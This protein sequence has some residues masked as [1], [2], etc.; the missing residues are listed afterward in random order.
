[1]GDSSPGKAFSGQGPS[2]HFPVNP[3]LLG[4]CS[5]PFDS[6]QSQSPVGA[7][8]AAPCLTG[9]PF[10][11]AGSTSSSLC[12]H[13]V[14][15]LPGSKPPSVTSAA[16]SRRTSLASLSESV[17]LMGE[18][19][20]DDGGFSTRPFVRSVQRQ[21]LSSRSSVTS[22]LATNENGIRPSWSLSAKLQ[23]RSNSASPV[24]GSSGTLERIG[25][26]ADD[27][28][29]TSCFG[30]RRSLSGSPVEPRAVGSSS[31]GQQDS[32]TLGRAPLAVM[33]GVLRDDAP[34][35]KAPSK[36]ALQVDRNA[37]LGPFDNNN[38]IAFV[39]QSDSVESSP[40]KDGQNFGWPGKPDAGSPL[41]APPSQESLGPGSGLKLGRA[42]LSSQDSLTS[43]RSV[44]SPPS[45]KALPKAPHSR[46]KLD[47]CR[48]SGRPGSPA[49]RPGKKDS[50][51][52]GP[53]SASAPPAQPKHRPVSSPSS[54]SA[55]RRSS[56]G[57][58]GRGHPPSGKGRTS[59]RGLS[60]EGS[61][62][63][64]GLEKMGGA[65]SPRTNS[66]RLGQ[67]RGEGRPPE[68][69]HVRSTSLASLRSPGPGPR[70]SLKRDSKSEEKGLSF[71]KSA[72]R[73]KE[74][75][76]S[77]DLGKTTLLAKKAGGGSCKA[78]GKTLSEEKLL[79]KA[80][81][82][83]ASVAAKDPPFVPTKR[84]LLTACKSQSSQPEGSLKSPG[85]G[86]GS[87]QQGSAQPPPRAT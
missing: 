69:K 16:S 55:A 49:A 7:P 22:P 87:H 33:E 25:E 32:R 39:D 85:G 74:T 10:P 57:G 26:S 14:S 29:A 12:E 30:S 59:E 43:H 51:G 66:P 54:S 78:V 62:L 34:A 9:W 81:L 4:Q 63:S 77:A 8:Q 56:S 31:R 19:S 47:S 35:W 70:P 71:F 79:E 58:S 64:M 6:Q 18:R 75:R 42:A 23:M 86:Q 13:W 3:H 53:E 11:L 5:D 83:K 28:V 38:Q 37:P 41:Q 44:A 2:P 27:R 84:S 72:L 48:A 73:Q 52:K 80:T 82:P 46:S 1:M 65:T 20:E 68:S 15:R 76:R 21:N 36:T 60:R 50:G 40:V 17:E 45:S 67:A 24:H 61:K